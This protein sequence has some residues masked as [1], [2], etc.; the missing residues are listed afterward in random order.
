MR[1]GSLVELDTLNL[2]ENEIEA[3]GLSELARRLNHGLA[4]LDAGF[5]YSKGNPGAKCKLTLQA[6]VD[7]CRRG[8]EFVFVEDTCSHTHSFP[9]ANQRSLS[10][11]FF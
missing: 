7:A 10:H 5:L 11:I 9:H 1:C 8:G 4:K 2:E 6:L 3:N